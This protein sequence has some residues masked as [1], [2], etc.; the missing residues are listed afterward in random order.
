VGKVS[1]K[2]IAADV[3]ADKQR[4]TFAKFGDGPWYAILPGM[5]EL[6]RKAGAEISVL[7]VSHSLEVAP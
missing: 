4:R 2:T 7:A 3:L 1:E 5:E 6:L